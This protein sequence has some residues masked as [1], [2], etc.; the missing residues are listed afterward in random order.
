MTEKERAFLDEL[1]AVCKKHDV[2]VYRH[3]GFP[4]SEP[5]FIGDEIQIRINEDLLEE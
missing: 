1:Q 2:G 3:C 4:D 5:Y